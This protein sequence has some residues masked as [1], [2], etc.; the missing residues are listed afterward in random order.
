MGFWIPLVFILVV[1]ML[2]SI[3]FARSGRSYEMDRRDKRELRELRMLKQALRVQATDH[4]ISDPFA[5][6]VLDEIAKQEHSLE[7]KNK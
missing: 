4:L 5:S 7:E 2:V 6:V 1:V 3:V